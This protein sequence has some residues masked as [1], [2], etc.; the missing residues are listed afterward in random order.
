MS[1]YLQMVHNPVFLSRK[2]FGSQKMTSHGYTEHSV[3]RWFSNGSYLLL[4]SNSSESLQMLHLLNSLELHVPTLFIR[5][6]YVGSIYLYFPINVKAPL[7]FA[8]P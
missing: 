3:L 8:Q 1:V 2:R 6:F 4:S 7:T 5:L